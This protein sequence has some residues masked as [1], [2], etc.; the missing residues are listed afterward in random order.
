[1]K[2]VQD[3]SSKLTINVQDFDGENTKEVPFCPKDNVY[4]VI[5]HEFGKQ[6]DQ[7]STVLLGDSYEVNPNDS[8]HDTCIEEGANLLVIFKKEVTVEEVVN[9]IVRLNPHLRPEDLMRRVHVDPGN[10]SGVE[11]ASEVR[12]VMWGHMG[13]NELPESMRYLKV[14]YLRL[15]D[16]NLRTLP[17]SF[18]CIAVGGH[19]D[20]SNNVLTTLPES[21][22]SLKLCCHLFLKGNPLSSVA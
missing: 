18:G 17:E 2:G 10:A 8:F 14:S 16:N 12:S 13:I 21:F 6:K 4:E 5:A 20:L 7:I 1:M 22:D 15:N 3:K 11:R 9:D 19:L